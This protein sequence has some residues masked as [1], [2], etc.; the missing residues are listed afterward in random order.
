[1]ISRQQI[2]QWLTT[3]L[4]LLVGGA[5]VATSAQ[6]DYNPVNPPEPNANFKVTVTSSHGYASGSG[7]YKSGDAAW[8]STSSY[9]EN[10]TFAYWTLNG[11][12]YS[13]EQSFSYA[14]TDRKADFVAVYAFTPVDPAEP[15]TPDT[16][17]LYLQTDQEG[18]CSFNRT[19][20]AK[21]KAGTY[22]Q[23]SATPS[24]GYQFKGWF[25]NGVKQSESLTFSYYMPSANTTL[26]ARF[27]YA[28]TS[29]DEPSSDS[30]QSG[31]ISKGNTGDAN[32][33]GEVNTADAVLII[34][35]YVNGTVD[36][37]N[38]AVTDINGDGEVNTTDAVK[39]INNYV[40]NE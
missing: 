12:K 6:T 36:T 20:G 18:S 13:E 21:A 11:E 4:L 3:W 1:M 40:N 39:L 33:D 31:N 8:I 2:S 29:P 9:N 10:Y 16:Y 17:R 38:K 5:M 19:S 34:N 37:L 26:E 30:S 24:P 35:H 7:T 25:V 23:V 14:V 28:P 22:I 27:V 15:V 32:G